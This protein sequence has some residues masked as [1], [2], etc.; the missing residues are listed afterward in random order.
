MINGVVLND[1]VVNSRYGAEVNRPSDDSKG[2]HQAEV[3]I[4]S[5]NA[6]LNGSNVSC[7]VGLEL[8]MVYILY[9]IDPGMQYV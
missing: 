3:V 6:T 4:R 5:V 2:R 1:P 9:I 8:R 7:A